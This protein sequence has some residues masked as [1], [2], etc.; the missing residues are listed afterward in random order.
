MQWADRHISVCFWNTRQTL[1]SHF[2]VWYWRRCV[3][4]AGGINSHAMGHINPAEY[5]ALWPCLW[6]FIAPVSA[7]W[8]LMQLSPLSRVYSECLR[9]LSWKLKLYMKMSFGLGRGSLSS[10]STRRVGPHEAMKL[11]EIVGVLGSKLLKENYYPWRVI[12]STSEDR[13]FWS[14]VWINDLLTYVLTYLP[15]Y[16]LNYLLTYLLTHLLTYLFTYILT[17]LLNYLLTYLRTHLLTY[18][19]TYLITY[20]TTYLH[21]YLLTYLHI[22]IHT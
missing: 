11:C 10:N 1:G 8:L 2:L 20:L 15:T 5:S 12:Y 18:L 3:E 16:L 14:K 7:Q 6:L 21:T 19:L 13:Y 17:Y 22:Y 9:C 4:A